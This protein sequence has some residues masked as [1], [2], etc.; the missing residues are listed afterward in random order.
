MNSATE[1]HSDT[2]RFGRFELRRAARR[3]LCEGNDTALGARAF[4]L[5]QALVERRDRIVD[6]DEL[7]DA[8]WPGLV[9]EE[10]NLTVQISVLRKILGPHAIATVH[11]RG[12][13]FTADVDDAARR[14]ARA[15]PDRLAA[16]ESAP[17]SAPNYLPRQATSFIG[18][19]NELV[20]VGTLL[21]RARIVSVLGPGGMGKTR[22]AC[23]VARRSAEPYVDGV[24][25]VDLAPQTSAE[26][27]VRAVARVL[28]VRERPGKPLVD[29][30]CAKAASQRLLLVLDNCE[31]LLDACR[32]FAAVWLRRTHTPS[33][34]ATS[35]EALG[36]EGEL[37][38]ALPAL[39]LPDPHGG[40]DRIE[41]V[42]AVRLFVERAQHARP[43]FRLDPAQ[44]A[45]LARLC[46]R[47]DGIPLALE[48]A[49]ARI[50]VMS[51][52]QILDR[53]DHRFRLLTGGNP[54]AP[55]RHQT[56]RATI[57][58][59]HA[60]LSENEQALHARLAVFAGGFTLEAAQGVCSGEGLDEWAV[61]D[62]LTSLTRKSM[63]Q[64][65][66]RQGRHRF[67][68]LE[69]VRQY[70]Q[71]RLHESA[72][73]TAWRERHLLW[74]AALAERTEPV[75]DGPDAQGALDTLKAEHD[76]L[77]IALRHAEPLGHVET[78]LRLAAALWRYWSMRGHGV[79]VRKSLEGLLAIGDAGQASAVRAKALNVLGAIAWE[80]GD[81]EAAGRAHVEG[82]AI[83]RQLGN[84][85]GIAS[86]LNNLGNLKLARNDFAAAEAL[87][88]ESLA[89][90]RELGDRKGESA[91]LSNLGVTASERGDTAR[92]K[93]LLAESLRID[94]ALGARR[95]LASKLN[96]LGVQ[97]EIE[98]DL[99]SARGLYEESL[100]IR[101]DL[102]DRA[103]MASSLGS[104][105][106]VA[107]ATGNFA[108]AL[109]LHL[110]GLVIKRGIDDRRGIA[111]S[112]EGLAAV[113]AGLREPLRA[114][115]LFGAAEQLRVE[116]GVPIPA[117]KRPGHDKAVESARALA[118]SVAVFDENWR[119]GNLMDLSSAVAYALK[120]ASVAGDA[121]AC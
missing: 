118:E 78:G 41:A 100:A 66:D 17:L 55:G 56:L 6:K 104:L 32:E 18:R 53:L 74:F 75:L 28:D 42:A 80:L 24:W 81:R 98:G 36:L 108:V 3:L 99:E 90:R 37:C 83:Q 33:L 110:D 31:H 27:V 71:A 120:P 48:L 43:Q 29:A 57:D 13:R 1:D 82:L 14:D 26:S 10:S 30:V 65:E 76:N 69:T 107:C 7:L 96:N 113:W 5:L 23:E 9:V 89:L 45:A 93:V 40:H 112:L 87:Y 109:A 54:D 39:A 11:G 119:H 121:A 79:E 49:A 20:E 61:L 60:L 117:S 115:R 44:S 85:F 67:G 50:A 34:L 62:A 25:F 52:E 105:G 22:L 21:G 103:G 92:A 94:R 46:V 51:V 101:T 91:T 8:A 15:A 12:Y 77:R 70:A 4:D 84:R 35:R 111:F 102:R 64:F 86:S 68:L 106:G 58:W 16:P 19:E 116:I 114:A 97:F 72:G 38:Y 2:I 88:E 47:L 95:S 63:V 73:E 59:S